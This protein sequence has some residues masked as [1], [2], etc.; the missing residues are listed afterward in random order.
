MNNRISLWGRI[1]TKLYL[2]LGLAVLLTLLSSAVAI[3]HFEKSG[4]LSHRASQQVVPVLSGALRAEAAAVD[5]AAWAAYPDERPSDLNLDLD[6]L[7]PLRDALS[8]PVGTPELSVPSTALYEDAATL[9]HHVNVAVLP[10]AA[11]VAELDPQVVNILNRV[12]ALPEDE[13]GHPTLLKALAAKTADDVDVTMEEFSRLAFNGLVSE[14]VADAASGDE[15][16][17]AILSAYWIQRERLNDARAEADR[18][19]DA[20]TVQAAAF[21]ESAQQFADAGVSASVA[22]FDNGRLLLFGICIISV[23]VAIV[24]SWLWVGNNILRRLARLSGMMRRMAGGDFETPITAISGDEIGQLANALE[25]FRQQALE[26]QRLNLVESLYGALQTAYE[27]KD[28][29]QARLVAQ[30]KLAALGQLV[31]GVAHEISNPLNFVKNFT[32]G[33]RE[34]A[35]ELFEILEQDELSDE[36]KATITGIRDDI[37]DSLDRVLTNGGRALAI[38]QRMQSFGVSEVRPSPVNLNDLVRRGSEEGVRTFVAEF[39]EFITQMEYGFADDIGDVVA[40]TRDVSESV[41]NLV[42]NA[43]YAMMM[44]KNTDGEGYSPLLTVM[45]RLVDEDTAAVLVTDN[46]TGIP[47]EVQERMFNPFFTTRDGASGAGLGLTLAADLA[48]RTGGG[49]TFETEVGGGTAFT[50]TLPVGA[51]EES[52]VPLSDEVAGVRELA[53]S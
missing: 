23:V 41:V 53:G 1:G 19:A 21:A 11:V 38:V 16:V 39:P 25:G 30:E 31:S 43:C 52:E 34:L 9:V 47:E 27:E 6:R 48:A 35:G 14:S 4:D 7:E 5:I 17:F 37:E 40:M 36:D 18:S 33:S 2:A 8:V 42:T 3:Y 28:A 49:I 24:T 13:L 29:L 45:T 50:M 26:V 32:E 20:L 12:R 15:G 51:V 22:S 10:L 44:K 46:G